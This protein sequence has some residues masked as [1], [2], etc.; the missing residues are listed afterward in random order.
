[1]LNTYYKNPLK[2]LNYNTGLITF[3][4]GMT[5]DEELNQIINLLF[6]NYDKLILDKINFF[7]IF[8]YI[9]RILN[10]PSPYF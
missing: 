3:D 10:T 7:T 4:I 1:M 9:K 2:L 5:A 8:I 6:V